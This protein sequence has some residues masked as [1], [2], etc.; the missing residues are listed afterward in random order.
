MGDWI[1]MGCGKECEWEEPHLL[2]CSNAPQPYVPRVVE[3]PVPEPPH[4]AQSLR[5]K[6]MTTNDWEEYHQ[7][8]RNARTSHRRRIPEFSEQPAGSLWD[9]LRYW[10]NRTIKELFPWQTH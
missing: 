9:T 2:N 8:M 6:A 5:Y 1:C 3:T 7:Y 10:V 4:S